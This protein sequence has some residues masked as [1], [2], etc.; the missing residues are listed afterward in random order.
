VDRRRPIS[1]DLEQDACG[2]NEGR[3]RRKKHRDDIERDLGVIREIAELALIA[4]VKFAD[5]SSPTRAVS[6]RNSPAVISLASLCRRRAQ[7][8]ANLL[9]QGLK[10]ASAQLFSR[11]G[12]AQTSF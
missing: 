2:D 12:V 3:A 1:G 6:V 7:V 10:C 11:L 5:P 4:V 9:F 8:Y